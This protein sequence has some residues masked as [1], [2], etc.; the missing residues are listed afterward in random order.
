[1][2]IAALASLF[3][4]AIFPHFVLSTINP[5]FSVTLEKQPQQ[6]RDRSSHAL[7]RPDRDALCGNLYDHDL[8]IFRGKVTLDSKSY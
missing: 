2:V 5:E 1:M 6:P 7:D 4:V 3:S 8:L